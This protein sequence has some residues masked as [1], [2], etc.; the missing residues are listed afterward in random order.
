MVSQQNPMLPK[1]RLPEFTPQISGCARSQCLSSHINMMKTL[2]TP[3][4]KYY[5]CQLNKYVLNVQWEH[6]EKINIM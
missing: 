2:V 4:L 3:T 1:A 5:D 6:W